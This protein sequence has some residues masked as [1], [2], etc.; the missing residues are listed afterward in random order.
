MHEPWASFLRDLDAQLN[1]ATELHC[2]GGFVVAEHYG[3]TR[4]TADIDIIRV[5]GTGPA[6]L[7]AMAG[8]GSSL[9][10]NVAYISMWSQSRLFQQTMKVA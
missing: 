9:H 7:T 1:E 10:K 6:A 3:L 4:A 8:K 5:R 2:F